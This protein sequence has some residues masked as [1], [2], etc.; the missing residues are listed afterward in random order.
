[1]ARCIQF[2][3]NE[4]QEP[5]SLNALDTKI[6]ALIGVEESTS[7]YGGIGENAYPWFHVIGGQIAEGAALNSQELRSAVEK[8]HNYCP[9]ARDNG[10][11]ILNFLEENFTSRSFWG[12]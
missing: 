10:V 12:R 7:R 11:K 5:I 2:I 4:T 6:C 8:W 9:E 3:S 1:M